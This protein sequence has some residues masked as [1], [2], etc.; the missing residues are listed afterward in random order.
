MTKTTFRKS[1]EVVY[2]ILSV[3]IKFKQIIKRCSVRLRCQEEKISVVPLMW[4]QK[5]TNLSAESLIFFNIKRWT[6][7]VGFFD[8]KISVEPLCN[9]STDFSASTLQRTLCPALKLC[10]FLRS[11]FLTLYLSYN[12]TFELYRWPSKRSCIQLEFQFFH[13]NG[14]PPTCHVFFCYGVKNKR[15]I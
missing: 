8:G 11:F 3:V 12:V 14:K 1:V 9:A 5:N 13:T 6:V 7:N 2:L 10:I 15:V 4:T